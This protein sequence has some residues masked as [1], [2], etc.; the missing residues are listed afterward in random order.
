MCQGSM[1]SQHTNV[2][3]IRKWRFTNER[4]SSQYCTR[5]Y[6]QRSKVAGWSELNWEIYIFFCLCL[7]ISET[8]KKLNF[9]ALFFLTPEFWYPR[10]RKRKL[11]FELFSF[12]TSGLIMQK[13]WYIN[14]V[15]EWIWTIVDN[16][17]EIRHLSFN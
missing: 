7:E 12:R 16:E 11:V 9:Q 3:L 6:V 14:I 8:N 4:L 2:L 10:T 13:L 15:I 17:L 1:A 5:L